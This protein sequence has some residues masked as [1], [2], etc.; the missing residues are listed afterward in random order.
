M[1]IQRTEKAHGA[2]AHC[3]LGNFF[4]A[5][6]V[7]G[8]RGAVM[9]RAN[10]ARFAGRPYFTKFKWPPVAAATGNSKTASLPPRSALPSITSQ[11][12]ARKVM[13][14]GCSS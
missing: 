2:T 14:L 4:S 5:K 8:G 6:G 3:I 7:P 11:F 1:R 9:R 13:I 10:I 12:F